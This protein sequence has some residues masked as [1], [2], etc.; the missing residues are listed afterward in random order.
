M[1]GHFRMSYCLHFPLYAFEYRLGMSHFA[2]VFL[3]FPLLATK[4][5]N[6]SD[7][8]IV[9]RAYIFPGL[10]EFTDFS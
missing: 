6:M 10:L 3:S 4:N 1:T 5:N 7:Q 9:T 2:A 8:R